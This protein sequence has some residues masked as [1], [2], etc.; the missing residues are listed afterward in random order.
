LFIVWSSGID[1]LKPLQPWKAYKGFLSTAYAF[2][3]SK[4]S[5]SLREAPQ[6]MFA[7]MLVTN[8]VICFCLATTVL[9]I[10][11]QEMAKRQSSLAGKNLKVLPLGDSITVW[12]TVSYDGN[13]V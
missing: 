4:Y 5:K 9:G 13:N 7:I 12:T 2:H 6:N 3:S 1:R 10:P 8:T 11:L